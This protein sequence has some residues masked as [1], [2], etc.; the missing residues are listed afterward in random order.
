MAISRVQK[1]KEYRN[2]LIKEEAPDF[3]IP[4]SSSPEETILEEKDATSTLPIDQVMD[5]INEDVDEE[6]LRRQKKRKIF[7]ISLISL[8]IL[9]LIAGIVV[10]AVLVF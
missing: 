6:F 10:F 7:L 9:L 3:E 4:K 1:F 8:G 2:S 5:A